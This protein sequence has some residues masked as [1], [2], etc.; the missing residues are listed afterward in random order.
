MN[1]L[2]D[3]MRNARKNYIQQNMFNNMPN[4]HSDP[5]AYEKDAFADAYR[6]PRLPNQPITTGP[7]PQ[8]ALLPA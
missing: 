2:A 5:L 1:N 4:K 3:I 6:T 8:K 7:H